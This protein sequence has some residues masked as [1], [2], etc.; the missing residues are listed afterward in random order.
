MRRRIIHDIW[1]TPHDGLGRRFERAIVQP[2]FR[3][4][5]GVGTG[6]RRNERNGIFIIGEHEK[7]LHV[8]H[9]CA[10]SGSNCRCVHIQR[11]REY[12]TED[13][14]EQDNSWQE[15]QASIVPEGEITVQK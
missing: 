6:A 11:L 8:I 15:S 10:Y 12:T 9:D 3:R 13:T 1:E 4:Y 5:D 14:E 2:L 7:H